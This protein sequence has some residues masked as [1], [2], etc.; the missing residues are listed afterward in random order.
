MAG[1]RC[2]QISNERKANSE[3]VVEGGS[4]TKMARG[5]NAGVCLCRLIGTEQKAWRLLLARGKLGKMYT[6]R[7]HKKKKNLSTQKQVFVKAG[8]Q[9][10]SQDV[11]VFIS[12][13]E[14]TGSK[15]LTF[16]HFH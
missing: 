4:V 6:L 1:I 9:D 15:H 5:D 2:P 7:K 11:S 8:W 13:V 14:G 12:T 10:S 16:H 3:K